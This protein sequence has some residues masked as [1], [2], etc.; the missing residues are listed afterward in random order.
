[1]NNKGLQT[2]YR[3][4]NKQYFR[5]K[6]PRDAKVHFRKIK[7]LGEADV[8]RGKICISKRTKWSKSISLMTLLHEMVHLKRPRGE[9]H[10]PGFQK[11]MLRL[12]KAGAF[13]DLW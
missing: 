8:Y 12:A 2:Y 11:E 13:K 1:M 6:L 3:L 9:C 4:Y 7:W 10:G 5:N